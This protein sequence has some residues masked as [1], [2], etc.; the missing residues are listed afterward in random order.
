MEAPPGIEPGMEVLQTSALPLGDGALWR[1][2][3]G[4]QNNPRQSGRKAR[5]RHDARSVKKVIARVSLSPL[6]Y[7]GWTRLCRMAKIA[8]SRRLETPVFSKIFDRWCFTVCALIAR[9]PAI[10]RLLS[11]A[12]IAPITSS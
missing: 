3:T 10:T 5:Q 1:K 4:E 2:L 9:R 11:P 12:T 8:S 6:A 7:F